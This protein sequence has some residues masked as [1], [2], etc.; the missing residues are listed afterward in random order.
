MVILFI[1]IYKI[2]FKHLENK[3]IHKND[4]RYQISK[5]QYIILLELQRKSL[6]KIQIPKNL[7]KYVKLII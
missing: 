4:S 5:I 3:K 2:N 6:L 7:L 1:N